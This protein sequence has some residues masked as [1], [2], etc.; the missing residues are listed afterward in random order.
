MSIRALKRQQLLTEYDLL[1][2][3]EI[4]PYLINTHEY[5]T[6]YRKV[7]LSPIDVKI[8]EWNTKRKINISLESDYNK[9]VGQSGEDFKVRSR[10][11]KVA[12]RI[13]L[14]RAATLGLLQRTSLVFSRLLSKPYFSK[15]VPVC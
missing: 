4:F 7:T 12:D 9:E 5:R 10:I 11:S 13:L 8:E 2:S 14:N 6:V 1:G 15:D 3:L